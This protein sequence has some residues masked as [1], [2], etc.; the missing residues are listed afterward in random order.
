MGEGHCS[1]RVVAVAKTCSEWMLVLCSK[2][3]NNCFRLN[4]IEEKPHHR[5][6]QLEIDTYQ[7]CGL[8]TCRKSIINVFM[9]LARTG[10][11]AQ[12]EHT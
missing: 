10:N 11:Q 8:R 6:P 1:E 2:R 9:L 7:T 5:E 3:C 4:V 12:D